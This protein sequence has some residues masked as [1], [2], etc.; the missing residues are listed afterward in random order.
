MPEF[1]FAQ[2]LLS[3]CSFLH[4][5]VPPLDLGQDLGL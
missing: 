5:S 2:E 3:R 4:L 1:V